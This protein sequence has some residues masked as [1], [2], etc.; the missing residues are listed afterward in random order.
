MSSCE[1]R[2]ERLPLDGSRVLPCEFGRESMTESCRTNLPETA[3]L[4]GD[5]SRS[6]VK[7]TA[8]GRQ[9]QQ[10]H[11]YNQGGLLTFVCPAE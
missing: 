5:L 10:T 7:E 11:R 2:E 8:V 1:G 4:S 9:C 6:R 3:M